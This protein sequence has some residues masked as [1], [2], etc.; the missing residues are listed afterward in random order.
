MSSSAHVGHC[1]MR[2]A[3]LRHNGQLHLC[4]RDLSIGILDPE[5]AQ[6]L[7][8]GLNHIPLRAWD[9]EQQLATLVE[10]AQYRQSA[11]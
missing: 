6:L 2:L 10:A 3:I 4:T 7:S 8:Q 11:G 5:L 1:L 9:P